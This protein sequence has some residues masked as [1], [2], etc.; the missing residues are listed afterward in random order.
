MK[1][2]VRKHPEDGTGLKSAKNESVWSL[3]S[4]ATGLRVAS[5]K[6]LALCARLKRL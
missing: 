1:S 5:G 4:V 6:L 2:Q 3:L